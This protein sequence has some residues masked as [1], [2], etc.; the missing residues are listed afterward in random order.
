MCQDRFT[1]LK[2]RL[3]GWPRN[4]TTQACF[5]GGF[6]VVWRHKPRLKL[7]CRPFADG[8][9]PRTQVAKADGA[10]REDQ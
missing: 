3:N 8:H 2:Q 4:R 6:H 1:T 5:R 9:P 10:K 7:A